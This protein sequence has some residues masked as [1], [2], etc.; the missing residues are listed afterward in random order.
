MQELLQADGRIMEA[1]DK[2]KSTP[3]HLASKNGHIRVVELLIEKR[4]LINSLDVFRKTPLHVASENGHLKIVDFLT[5]SCIEMLD[6][7]DFS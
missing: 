1:K 7:K 5:Q 4:A 6:E 2:N 3:L